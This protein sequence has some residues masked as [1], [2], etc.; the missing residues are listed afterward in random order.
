MGQIDR[1]QFLSSLAAATIAGSTTTLWAQQTTQ[2]LAQTPPVQATVPKRKF[3]KIGVEVSIL[4]LGGM[5]DIPNNQLMLKKA[6]DWGVSYWDTADCYGNGQ[7]EE[8]IGLL[9]Y[10]MKDAFKQFFLVT[11]SDRRDPD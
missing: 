3:G 11:K 10:K 2:S 9:F 1:R 8:G 4:S 7:S 5:F 6:L